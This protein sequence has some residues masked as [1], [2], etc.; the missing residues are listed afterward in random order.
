[1]QDPSKKAVFFPVHLLL[2]SLAM[3]FA[4]VFF[5]DKDERSR[6]HCKSI[7]MTKRFLQQ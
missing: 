3:L 1:M 7:K 4:F 5:M 6:R 2:H